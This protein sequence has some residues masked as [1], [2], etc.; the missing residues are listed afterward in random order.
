MSLQ[1]DSTRRTRGYPERECQRLKFRM[2]ALSRPG[3]FLE[4][5]T[6]SGVRIGCG[7]QMDLETA[8]AVPAL[9]NQPTLAYVCWKKKP[10]MNSFGW[11][12]RAEPVPN[13]THQSIWC[14]VPSRRP[15]CSSC[16]PCPREALALRASSPAPEEQPAEDADFQTA[17]ASASAEPGE[18]TA[19]QLYHGTRAERAAIR[20]TQLGLPEGWPTRSSP[21]PKSSAAAAEE[22]KAQ[23]QAEGKGKG[24]PE[25]KGKS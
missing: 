7:I 12:F 10:D 9:G 6:T 21:V 14:G 3:I 18:L 15:R 11:T 4:W 20:R 2:S 1:A 23:A 24:K 13:G 5:K 25:G 8:N 22:L 17:A 19:S 16:C